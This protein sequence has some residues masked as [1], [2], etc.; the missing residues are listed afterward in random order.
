M[1]PWMRCQVYRESPRGWGTAQGC[2]ENTQ[3]AKGHWTWNWGCNPC[4]HWAA[5]PGCHLHISFFTKVTLGGEWWSCVFIFSVSSWWPGTLWKETAAPDFILIKQQNNF[6]VHFLCFFFYCYRGLKDSCIKQVTVPQISAADNRVWPNP[7]HEKT[8]SG[9]Q[10]L[11]MLL[12]LSNSDCQVFTNTGFCFQT[13]WACF[14]SPIKSS[15]ILPSVY[16]PLC[17]YRTFPL[18][19]LEGQKSQGVPQIPGRAQGRGGNKKPTLHF[20]K[21][22]LKLWIL[23]MEMASGEPLMLGGAKVKVKVMAEEDTFWF[24]GLFKVYTHGICSL[25]IPWRWSLKKSQTKRRQKCSGHRTCIW[26]GCTAAESGSPPRT[27]R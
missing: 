25:Q 5:F 8:Y 6:P 19:P 4:D 11:K 13:L 22:T 21:I 2:F 16:I 18:H 24:Y 27:H 14:R 23:H 20:W 7:S 1:H 17:L 3:Q 10:T 26:G 15:L 12:A 9:Y